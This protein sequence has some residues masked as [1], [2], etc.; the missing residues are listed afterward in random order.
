M[1][2]STYGSRVAANNI[3]NVSTPGY[4]RQSLLQSTAPAPLLGVKVDGV[5]RNID[6]LLGGHLRQQAGA[7]AGGSTR[8]QF[9]SRI[10]SALDPS[11]DGGIGAKLDAM[12]AAYREL[13]AAPTNSVMRSAAL[14]SVDAVT[15]S[16]RNAA[17]NL[18]ELQRDADSTMVATVNEANSLAASVARLNGAIG[19]AGT[20]NTQEVGAMTDERDQALKRLSELIGSEATIDGRNI[21]TVTVGGVGIVIGDTQR[22]MSTPGTATGFHD[23]TVEAPLTVSLAGKLGPSIARS[24]LTTRD[25]TVAQRLAELDT[26]AR[27]FAGALNAV[28]G[29]HVGLDGS[30]G[31]ALV[32]TGSA[33]GAATLA[34]DPALA[35][36][37]QRLATTSSA[38]SPGNNDGIRAFL[39]LETSASALG[40]TTTL[41]ASA[42]ATITAAGNEASVA[43]TDL[44]VEQTRLSQLEAA[45]EQ[46]SGVSIADEMIA[47]EQYQRAYQANARVVSTINEMLDTLMQM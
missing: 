25:T 37:P 42:Q 31:L 47:L 4:S 39:Q 44:K 28:Q 43:G 33:N 12:F 34:I 16:V 45:R 21:A 3:A 40:G 24:A 18:T 46:A 2:A 14:A 8:L 29:A 32:T 1:S 13:S 17:A 5:R 20:L 6:Q 10:E 38:S 23:I 11:G 36:Q 30:T 19:A 22:V 15:A 41:Q 26:F 7:A 9:A 27:D 35:G